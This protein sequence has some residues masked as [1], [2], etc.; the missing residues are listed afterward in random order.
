MDGTTCANLAKV[1][2]FKGRDKMKQRMLLVV[3]LVT[4]AL[5]LDVIA[6]D[7]EGPQ[8]GGRRSPAALAGTGFT[9]QVQL[10]NDIALVNGTCEFQFGL[11]DALTLGA[12]VGNTQTIASAV[13]NGLFTVQLN[14]G[15]QITTGTSFNG[16]ARWLASAVRCPNGTGSYTV[17]NPRQALTPAPRV[18]APRI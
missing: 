4:F 18:C 9:Y 16:D 11:W 14:A 3:L 10:K 7:A 17:L 6:V 5:G 8:P 12:Q 2:N 15:G 13:T 1:K